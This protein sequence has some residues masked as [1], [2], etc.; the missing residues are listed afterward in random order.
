MVYLIVV[1][2]R[3]LIENQWRLAELL[4]V[5]TCGVAAF[6]IS[7]SFFSRNHEALGH[8]ARTANVYHILS[9]ILND[10]IRDRLRGLSLGL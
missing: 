6:A 10:L 7:I 3:L 1:T 9:L 4:L 2:L 8:R 5:L